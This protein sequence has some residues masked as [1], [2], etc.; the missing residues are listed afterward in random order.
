VRRSASDTVVTKVMSEFLASRN[1]QWQC[2]GMI[3]LW[4][5]WR[6]PGFAQDLAE[7]ADHGEGTTVVAQWVR[8]RSSGPGSRAVR[9]TV[10]AQVEIQAGP[11]SVAA[12]RTTSV[13]VEIPQTS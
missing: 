12:V 7:S 5:G 2:R 9:D 4:T 11:L 10:V 3:P 1:Y 6:S 8:N 13:S